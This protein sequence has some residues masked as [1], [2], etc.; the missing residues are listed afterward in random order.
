MT[1]L[2][3][4]ICGFQSVIDVLTRSFTLNPF[5]STLHITY[6]SVAKVI[7]LNKSKRYLIST[8]VNIYIFKIP[9]QI[10]VVYK[11]HPA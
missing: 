8:S 7:K 9:K 5:E 1:L 3:Y 4:S 6:E 2:V 11:Y 10:E